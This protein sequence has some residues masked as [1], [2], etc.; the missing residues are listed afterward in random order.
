MTL[1]FEQNREGSLRILAVV[2]SLAIQGADQVIKRRA[3]VV[4]NVAD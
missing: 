1:G 3:S 2:P 4:D